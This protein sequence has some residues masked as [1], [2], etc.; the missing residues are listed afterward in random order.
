MLGQAAKSSRDYA[1]V[2]RQPSERFPEFEHLLFSPAGK[3]KEL[4]DED[5]DPH[6]NPPRTADYERRDLSR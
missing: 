1:H 5:N 3:R 2:Q 4:L 6:I